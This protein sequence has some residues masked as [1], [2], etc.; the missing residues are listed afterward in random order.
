MHLKESEE[1]ALCGLD[2]KDLPETDDINRVLCERCLKY[3]L[4]FETLHKDAVNRIK[5]IRTFVRRNRQY[6]TKAID[7]KEPEG[8]YYV[9]TFGSGHLYER[10]YVR[11][12]A[13]YESEARDTM[14]KI[15]G[16]FWAT[17]YPKGEEV[18][19]ESIP[20]EAWLMDIRREDLAIEE[21]D[22]T[23]LERRLGINEP[24]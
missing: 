13:D 22:M 12:W 15:F 24:A 20:G 6:I 4:D 16:L 19:I 7:W 21:D 17:S 23:R 8:N 18:N 5:Q 11:I 2:F 14:V 10:S 9:I 3:A 1:R